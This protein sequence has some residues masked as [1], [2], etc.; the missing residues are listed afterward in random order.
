M[1]LTITKGLLTDLKRGNMF[2]SESCFWTES[3]C[4]WFADAPPA[5]AEGYYLP[6]KVAGTLQD[7]DI[8]FCERRENGSVIGV[9][10]AG[11]YSEYPTETG[12]LHFQMSEPDGVA[13]RIK[14]GVAMRQ[15]SDNIAKSPL[16]IFQVIRVAWKSGKLEISSISPYVGYRTEL[17]FTAYEE[18][19]K[20]L[21]IRADAVKELLTVLRVSAAEDL[22]I[23]LSDTSLIIKNQDEKWML[24]VPAVEMQYPKTEELWGKSSDGLRIA[25]GD[26]DAFLKSN[27]AL[28]KGGVLKLQYTATAE[29]LSYK[30]LPNSSDIVTKGNIPL[31]NNA[32]DAFEIKIKGDAFAKLCAEAKKLKMP[33]TMCPRKD[34][35]F[36][37]IGHGNWVLTN[38]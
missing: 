17:N 4:K 23:S 14:V 16:S 37:T 11:G 27:D 19:K 13:N 3:W 26:A 18:Q 38:Q 34:R 25:F 35:V 10:K 33:M 36:I 12:Q 7:G 5:A 24:K 32:D 28:K 29:T 31:E 6:K 22:E 15:A 30:A 1:K 9:Q 21:F 8:L 20:T 2:V